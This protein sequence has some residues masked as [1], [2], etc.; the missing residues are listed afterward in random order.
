MRKYETIFI[1][2]P[3][4]G[5]EELKGLTEK[6]QE[7]ISGMKGEC[8]R[9]EDW[10]V[11]KLAYPVKKCMRGRY[12][13]LNFTGNS[14]LISELERRLRLDDKVIR[15]QSVKL[16]KEADIAP[17]PVEKTAPPQET[18]ETVEEASATE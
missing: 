12:F 16:E 4:L 3:E 15:Y 1:A 18:V 14:A 8:M 9:L 17:A 6:V 2:Q 13:Y 5:E 7:V 10:G 11:R